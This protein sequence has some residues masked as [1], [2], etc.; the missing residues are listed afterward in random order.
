MTMDAKNEVFER[1]QKEYWG[2]TRKRKSEILHTVCAVTGMHNKAVVR[3]FRALR[4][5]DAGIPERRGRRVYYT[6]DVTLALR[7]VWE[8]AN[9]ICGELLHPMI[10]EYVTILER[11]KLW[12]HS[13]ETTG[14]LL[15][16]SEGTVKVRV[17]GFMKARKKRGGM[18]TTSPSLL[19]HI[20]PIATGPWEDAV[21]GEGQ[22]DTVAHCGDSVAGD[23]IYTVNY[24]DMATYWVIPRAQWNK[25]QEATLDSIKTIRECL[26]FPL[27]GL[28]PDSGSEFVNWLCK[29]WCDA[30][31]IALT[32]SRPNKKNDNC[33]VEERNGHIVR[34]FLG[35]T[36][37][38]A[39]ETVGAVNALYDVLAVYL[40]HFVPSRRTKE[41]VR[42]GAKYVRTYAKAMT[43]YARALAHPKISSEIK[44]MLRIAH[45]ALNP[46]LLKREVDRL[47]AT[48]FAKQKCCGDPGIHSSVR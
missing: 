16:M 11:D 28:H 12:T 10:A 14:K 9:E 1:F 4:L 7:A 44:A 21:P 17:G 40:N 31:E 30:G 3:K 13:D 6:H 20:I 22:I 35:Y 29:D 45:D 47:Q 38:D 18:S 39:R 23:F 46:L 36:R 15:A 32:R 2:A 26:P 5:H 33:Y 27:R 34:K 48:I 41:K 42:I 37:L 24:T 19:K 43:P 25:G 8:A